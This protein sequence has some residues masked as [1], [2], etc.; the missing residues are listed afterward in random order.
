MC[1]QLLCPCCYGDYLNDIKTVR[2]ASYLV[3]DMHYR[4]NVQVERVE[5]IRCVNGCFTSLDSV[6]N[7]M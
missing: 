7:D 3:Q 6:C 2:Q 1:G 4:D 5:L